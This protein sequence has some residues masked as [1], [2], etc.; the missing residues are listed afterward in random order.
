MGQAD[1]SMLKL[2]ALPWSAPCLATEKPLPLLAL[3]ASAPNTPFT[4]T[5]FSSCLGSPP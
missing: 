1:V 4:P 5:P 2:Q 3:L